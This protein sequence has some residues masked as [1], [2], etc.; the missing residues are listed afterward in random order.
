MVFLKSEKPIHVVAAV[1]SDGE[2][3]LIARKR[4]GKSL[5]GFWE[6]AGGK[7]E[8]GEKPEIALKREIKEELSLDIDVESRIGENIHHYEHVSIRL[9]AF[10]ANLVGGVLQLKDHDKVEWIKLESL[11]EYKLAPADIPIAEKLIKGF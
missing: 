11:L 10:H 1:I 9:E 3:I 7:V 5:A 4:Y 8:Q 6:F 2:N